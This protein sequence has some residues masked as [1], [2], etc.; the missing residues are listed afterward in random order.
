MQSLNWCSI[1]VTGCK[2]WQY[3]TGNI[4]KQIY[5]IDRLIISSRHEA[6]LEYIHPE[7]IGALVY[8]VKMKRYGSVIKVKKE[9]LD[10]YIRV[11]EGV[12]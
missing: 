8:V 9:C 3:S 2:I 1:T 12:W 4:K 7:N 10:E 11:H 5:K 6:I